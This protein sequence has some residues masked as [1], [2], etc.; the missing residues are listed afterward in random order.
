MALPQMWEVWTERG[1]GRVR[2]RQFPS[3]HSAAAYFSQCWCARL[4]VNPCGVEMCS[5]NGFNP[6][7]LQTLRRHVARACADREASHAAFPQAIDWCI[8]NTDNCVDNAVPHSAKSAD[9]QSDM[10]QPAPEP[11]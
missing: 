11:P 3:A 2:A 1:I 5:N 10:W 9:A 4:L 8:I 7:A 6:L